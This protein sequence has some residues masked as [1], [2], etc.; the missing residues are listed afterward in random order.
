[1]GAESDQVRITLGA[2]GGGHYLLPR[3]RILAALVQVVCPTSGPFDATDIDVDKAGLGE[4]SGELVRAME[5]GAGE[6][7][8]PDWRLMVSGSLAAIDDLGI[9]GLL[10]QATKHAV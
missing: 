8:G 5:V 3:G 7:A 9:P 6:P 1:M 10:Q 2:L 4:F